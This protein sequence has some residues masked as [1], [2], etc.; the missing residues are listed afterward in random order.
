MV[1]VESE[2]EE[3]RWAQPSKWVLVLWILAIMAFVDGDQKK[4]NNGKEKPSSQESA[5]IYVVEARKNSQN[6]WQE[7]LVADTLLYYDPQ[8]ADSGL[9]RKILDENRPNLRTDFS[10]PITMMTDRT[11]YSRFLVYCVPTGAENKDE[12]MKKPLRPYVKE[13]G[14]QR[15]TIYLMID[16]YL[17]N[18]DIPTKQ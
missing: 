15:E 17:N 3:R 13:V 8:Y 16:R 9:V 12:C 2:E 4:S 18:R 5:A 7:Y 14:A 11:K 6:Q 10:L 1:I